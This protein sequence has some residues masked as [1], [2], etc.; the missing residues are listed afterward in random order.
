MAIIGTCSLCGGPVDDSP[1][2]SLGYHPITSWPSSNPKPECKYC[3]AT[4]TGHG[5]VIHMSNPKT[6]VFAP[7]GKELDPRTARA[8][9]EYGCIWFDGFEFHKSK[10]FVVGPMPDYAQQPSDWETRNGN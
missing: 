3:H 1:R 2:S 10:P 9:L 5:P 8:A 6:Q 7:N 4:A